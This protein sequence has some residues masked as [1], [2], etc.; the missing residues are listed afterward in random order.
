MVP[1]K[2]ISTLRHVVWF[3]S[4]L[5]IF[6]FWGLQLKSGQLR[7][8]YLCQSSGSK[9]SK[10]PSRNQKNYNS[11]HLWKSMNRPNNVPYN[12]NL[13]NSPE[14]VSMWN[15]QKNIHKLEWHISRNHI[16]RICLCLQSIVS[17]WKWIS[18]STIAFTCKTFCFRPSNEFDDFV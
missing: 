9:S 18:L 15:L 1:S 17:F 10:K 13:L 8:D 6:F 14:C 7:Q 3:K 16:R 5:S 11:E 2:Q 12:T 4:L